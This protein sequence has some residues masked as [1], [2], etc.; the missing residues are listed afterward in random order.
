MTHSSLVRSGLV[1]VI[2]GCGLI[3]CSGSDTSTAPNTE[4]ASAITTSTS[5]APPTTAAPTTSSPTTSSPTT[6]APATTTTWVTRAELR[7]DRYCEVL[8]LT[9]DGE[10]AQATV[11]GSQGLN[12]CP[13][14]QFAALDAAAIAAE[15]KVPI[16]F[17]NGPRYWAID[18][19]QKRPDGERVQ[20]TFGSI[21]MNRLA[22]VKI[23]SRADAVLPY[24]ASA[25]SRSAIFTFETG[26]EI[27][28]LTDSAGVKY[29]MQ[30]WSQQ[31][32]PAL[33]E[34]DLPGLGARLKLPEGWTFST[35][36]LTE[37]LLV[38][39]MDEPAQVLQDDLRNSYSMETD[40]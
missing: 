12:E 7:G 24:V 6:E 36:T 35:R 33:S 9:P 4:P 19:L 14:E 23:A 37:P 18:A 34:A 38:V 11:F 30:S 28:E 39:T 29:V 2:A 25:V 8:L 15:N 20:Q 1:V 21:L 13:A 17:L 31:I 16:A 3:A 40:L 27:Y 26:S 10:G 22:T 5:A 32:D